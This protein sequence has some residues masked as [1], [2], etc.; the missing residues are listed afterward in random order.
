V[1]DVR[2]CGE[3]YANHLP[4]PSHLIRTSFEGVRTDIKLKGTQMG[5]D[6]KIDLKL[7]DRTKITSTWRE[8]WNG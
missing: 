3:C 6:R 4:C 1:P 8:D 5:Q 2:D 7:Q